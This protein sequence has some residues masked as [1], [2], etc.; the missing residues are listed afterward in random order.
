M[1]VDGRRHALRPSVQTIELG[2]RKYRGLHGRNEFRERADIDADRVPASGECFHQG[3]ATADMVIEH[4]VAW[5][6]ECV[7]GC[8]DE[9]RGKACGVFVEPVR[10]PSYRLRI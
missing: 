3:G 6:R 4:H 9:A 10:Q 1:D 2:L 7:D 8:T 5:L